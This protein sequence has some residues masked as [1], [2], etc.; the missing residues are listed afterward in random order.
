MIRAGRDGKGDGAL[1]EHLL[2]HW[3]LPGQH[4]LGITAL[5]DVD[6]ASDRR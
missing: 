2:L 6:W 3:F 1:P 4:F 5:L